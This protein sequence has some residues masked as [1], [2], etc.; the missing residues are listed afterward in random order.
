MIPYGLE[1]DYLNGKSVLFIGAGVSS[2]ITRN[3]GKHLPGWNEFVLELVEYAFTHG[4]INENE[5]SELIKLITEGKVLIAA[6][7]IIDDLKESE[8]Q[9]F[10]TTI[11]CETKPDDAIYPLICQMNFRALITTNFDTLIEDAFQRYSA[12]KIKT[13]TQID[14]KSNLALLDEQFLL[15]LHGTYERQETVALGLQGYL[16]IIYGNEMCMKI[17]E[18]LLLSNSFLFI[19]YGM[20]DIDFNSLLDYINYISGNNSRS[21]YL[22]VEKGIVT[23]YEKLYLKKHRNIIAIEYENKTGQHEGLVDL[24]EELK[25]KKFSNRK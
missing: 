3:N 6:Q 15:K 17:M 5:K 2:R 10:L 20:N 22:A 12:N 7:I 18:S 16:K 13:W 4:N 24:L 9:D 25:K 19:G 1:Q 23:P 14:V 21:H 8:F 11:F